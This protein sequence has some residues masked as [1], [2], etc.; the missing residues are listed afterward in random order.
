MFIKGKS[1]SMRHVT[2]TQRVDL[3]WLCERINLDETISIKFIKTKSPIAD[4][5]TK[6]QFTV[7]GRN[8]P[9][10]LFN[11]LA[12]ATRVSERE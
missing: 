3:G 12:E 10:S 6:G 8:K 11:L 2:R 7:H 4:I 5:L 9:I 1:R